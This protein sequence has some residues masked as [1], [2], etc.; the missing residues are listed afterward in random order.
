MR[1]RIHYAQVEER[2]ELIVGGAVKGAALFPQEMHTAL[3]PRT[4]RPLFSAVHYARVETGNARRVFIVSR[5]PTSRSKKAKER[6]PAQLRSDLVER[7]HDR[8]A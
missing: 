1:A 8:D 2:I 7:T 4:F 6:R 3:C 5:F